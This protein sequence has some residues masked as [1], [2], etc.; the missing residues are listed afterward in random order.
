MCDDSLF[1]ELIAGFSQSTSN[2]THQ[3]CKVACLVSSARELD[4]GHLLEG[5]GRVQTTVRK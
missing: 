5:N 4:T 1:E 3:P 2:A